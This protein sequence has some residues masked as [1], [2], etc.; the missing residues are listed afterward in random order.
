MPTPSQFS[1]SPRQFQAGFGAIG[2]IL[3]AIGMLSFMAII[4]AN[5]ARTDLQTSQT[6]SA[7]QTLVAQAEFIAAAIR[8]CQARMARAGVEDTVSPGSQPRYPGCAIANCG[9]SVNNPAPATA[10][11]VLDLSLLVCADNGQPIFNNTDETMLPS[12]VSGFNDWRYVKNSTGVYIMA[13]P[14]GSG[15]DTT[16]AIGN[17]FL[18][19]FAPADQFVHAQ[20]LTPTNTANPGF[21]IYIYRAP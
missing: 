15:N 2:L 13:R 19:K 4:M 5:Q 11:T 3:G 10:L 12:T 8:R 9:S 7:T 21:G 18:E 20:G 14:P 6:L 16:R 17:A 1:P